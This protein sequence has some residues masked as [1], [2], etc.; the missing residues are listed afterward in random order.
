M[1]DWLEMYVK[2]MQLDYRAS[3][4]CTKATFHGRRVG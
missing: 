3:T 2:V 4:A 1:G